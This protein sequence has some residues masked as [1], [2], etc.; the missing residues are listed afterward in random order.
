MNVRPVL[1]AVVAAAVIATLAPAAALAQHAVPYRVMGN[2]GGVSSQGN[3]WLHDTVGQVAVEPSSRPGAQVD[4][5]F[6][7]MIDRLHIG[8]TSAV[9]IAAFDAVCVDGVV[10]LTWTIGAAEGLRGL[11]IY[12]APGESGAFVLI[13]GGLLPADYT[14]TWRDNRVRPGTTYRYQLG[15]VDADGEFL[16]NVV[17]VVTPPAEAQLYQNYPNPFN[18]VTAISF[19]LPETARATLVIYDAAG[20]SVKRLFDGVVAFGRTDVSWDGT[21]DRGEAVSSGVYFYRLTAGKNVFTKKLTLL[22]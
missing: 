2:G 7:H 15:A 13:N 12:R 16:S 18:P 14:G 11:N 5:G 21:N 6:W 4:P 22:K 17:S 3:L 1:S 9:A 20:H 10:T 19:Y 8:P